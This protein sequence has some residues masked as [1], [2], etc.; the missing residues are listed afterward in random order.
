MTATHLGVT[1]TDD[2]AWLARRQL[3][4]GDARPGGAR[5]RHPRLSR[6]RERLFRGGDGRRRTASGQ[7]SSPRCAARI[8]EDDSSV[9]SPDGPYAYARPL[10]PQGAEHPLL[11]RSRRD[12]GDETVLLD[13]N[14][15]AD[16]Q[17]LFPPRRQRPQPRPPAPRLG[18]RRQG[19]GIFR[20]SASAISRPARTWP[21][22]S[23]A[24][25]ARRSGRRTA[26]R[27][28]Y[29]W[30]DD[31]HRPAKVFRHIDRHRPGGGRR[32][33]TR[34]AD[35]GFF[36]GVGKTQSDRF[37]VIDSHDHETSEVQHPRR[38]TTRRR[39]RASSRR[40]GRPSE[41]ELDEARRAF[42]HP[43]QRRRRRGLQD[44]HR[45]GRDARPRALAR[46]R[47]APGRAG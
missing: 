43:D 32:S 18:A 12:G 45:A 21:T 47:A 38:P 34:S 37:I 35:P 6:G 41:Y 11:V 17:G 24:P 44:R 42:L 5:A 36:L 7:R 23:P 31:N 15:L 25:P 30:L 1:R 33:S 2:Y 16:G 19:L 46:P 20:R 40:G 28:F 26:A 9:P 29:V 39:R 3:A 14:A 10:S 22:A 8:K 27:L 4:A 13:A